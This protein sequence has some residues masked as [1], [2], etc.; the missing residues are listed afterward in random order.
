M[1]TQESRLANTGLQAT[2]TWLAESFARL[3]EEHEV[4][5]AEIAV[6][7]GVG[8]KTDR[9]A[10]AQAWADQRGRRDITDEGA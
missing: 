1:S 8:Q 9:E 3:V 2:A 10:I 7:A 4:P 6:L 5:V